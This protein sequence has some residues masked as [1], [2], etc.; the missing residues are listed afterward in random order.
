MVAWCPL[1]FKLPLKFQ[2]SSKKMSL[3]IP[4]N[5]GPVFNLY[6]YQTFFPFEMNVKI[7]RF[8][9]SLNQGETVDGT[10]GTQRNQVIQKHGE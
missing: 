6:F 8:H 9:P 1:W 4:L 2:V 3:D 5:L 7:L 10:M